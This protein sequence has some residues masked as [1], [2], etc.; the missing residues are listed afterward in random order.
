VLANREKGEV[1]FTVGEQ[2]YTMR[3]S[4]NALC[5][6]EDLMST[7]DVRVTAQD[8]IARVNRGELTAVRA[9]LWAALREHHQTLTLKDVGSLL[10]T[11]GLEAV[12]TAFSA[13]TQ[14]LQPD[15]ADL[16][17]VGGGKTARPPK[18]ARAAASTGAR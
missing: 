5:E 18:A 12:T 9:L 3:L 16:D 10:E 8:V 2:A 14:S 17:T 13:L 15:K 7:R 11:A 6:L 1:S 4:L